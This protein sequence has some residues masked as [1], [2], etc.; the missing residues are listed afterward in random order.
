MSETYHDSFSYG[1]LVITIDAEG[2]REGDGWYI[3]RCEVTARWDGEH[4]PACLR[5]ALLNGII[6]DEDV[7][8]WAE[9]K[10]IN[11]WD[12]EASRS[13]DDSAEARRDAEEGARTNQ[14]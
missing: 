7:N 4:I 1:E 3:D 12:D 9:R 2:S 10:A 5:N 14:L 8:D 6:E 13:A 11:Y